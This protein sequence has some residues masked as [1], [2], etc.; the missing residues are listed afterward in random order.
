MRPNRGQIV[1]TLVATISGSERIDAR[2][3]VAKYGVAPGEKIDLDFIHY[4]YGGFFG[5][6][7]SPV[8]VPRFE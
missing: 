7:I 4:L 6:M 1:A 8:F 3:G 2:N 5:E